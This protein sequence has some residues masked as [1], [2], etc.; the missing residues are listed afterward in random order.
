M[1]IIIPSAATDQQLINVPRIILSKIIIM[2]R[3]LLAF[4]VLIHGLIH[5][6]GFAKAFGYGNITQLSKYISKPVGVF[7]LIAAILFIIATVLI[8]AHT[9]S[10]WIPGL[11][12]VVS[13]QILIFMIWQDA[14]FGTIANAIV[15]V[16][17]LLS[18]G[19]WQFENSY[20]KEV[21]KGLHRTGLIE[22]NNL[23]TDRDIE[24]LPPLVQSYLRYVGVLNKPKVKN[25]KIVFDGAMRDKGKDWFNFTSEQYNFFDIPTRLFFMKGRMYG[26]TVPGYHA[27]KNGRATMQIKMFGLFPIIN[28]KENVLNK[29]ET[30][31]AFNDMC[32]LAPATLI[33]KRIQWQPVDN[34]SVKATFTVNSISISAIL[35]FNE[36]GELINFISN[37]RYA[38]AD[39]KQYP[40]LTPVKEYRNINGYNLPGYGE[41]IWRYPEGDFSYGKFVLKQVE[42]NCK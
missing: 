7:W 35:Y 39:M 18:F 37:D 24:T 38:I 29:A 15:L 22:E 23:L 2:L 32:L 34:S 30:V 27:Y 36:K 3:F 41:A 11:I 6:I 28:A 14:K 8:L 1:I 5:L 25:V 13:S 17:A 10:W 16:A 4:L 31:T 42:Y 33:D 40:F 9:D 26:I 20:K 19:R 12:G 21:A